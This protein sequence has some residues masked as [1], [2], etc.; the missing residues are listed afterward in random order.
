MW[1]TPLRTTV[2]ATMGHS[3]TRERYQDSGKPPLV[4]NA[5]PEPLYLTVQGGSCAA[6]LSDCRKPIDRLR[7]H[8]RL[9]PLLST[10][11]CFLCCFLC[12]SL[13]SFLIIGS[14]VED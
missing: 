5:L 10:T 9:W 14:A 13:F 12:L 1:L 8:Q 11:S 3:T 6:G 4:D 7:N 2:S